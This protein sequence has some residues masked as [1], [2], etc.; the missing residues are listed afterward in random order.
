M[1]EPPF[2]HRGRMPVFNYL[3]DEEVAA[4]YMYLVAYPPK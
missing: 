2:P 4:G 1:G 3:R